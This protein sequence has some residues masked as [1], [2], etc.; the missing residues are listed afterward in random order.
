M[1]WKGGNAIL[2]DFLPELVPPAFGEDEG[3]QAEVKG[4]TILLSHSLAHDVG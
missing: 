4:A 1:F 3:S 2:V